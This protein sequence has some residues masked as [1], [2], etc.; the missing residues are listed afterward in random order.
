MYTYPYLLAGIEMAYRSLGR[1]AVRKG[2]KPLEWIGRAEG[3]KSFP[4][5]VEP[6]FLAH[7]KAVAKDRQTSVS[8]MLRYVMAVETGYKAPVED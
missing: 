5:M 7:L 6:H 4:W 8:Q 1:D 3:K 2:D